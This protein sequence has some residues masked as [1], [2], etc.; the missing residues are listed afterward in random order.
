LYDDI[1]IPALENYKKS[2][3]H[4]IEFYVLGKQL[5]EI[6][7]NTIEHVQKAQRKFSVY[8]NK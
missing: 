1:I 4:S 2:N 3:G 8:N 6:Y 5:N 7:I